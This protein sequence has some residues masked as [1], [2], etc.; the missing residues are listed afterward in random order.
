MLSFVTAFPRKGKGGQVLQRHIFN[1]H[2]NS[3][4]DL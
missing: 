4:L 3:W 1:L 2:L